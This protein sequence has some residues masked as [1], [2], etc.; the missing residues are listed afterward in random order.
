LTKNTY[1]TKQQQR[2]GGFEKN[3]KEGELIGEG[4]GS[5]LK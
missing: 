1:K 3:G 2:I 4:N 5:N